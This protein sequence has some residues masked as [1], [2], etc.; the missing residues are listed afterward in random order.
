MRVKE[1]SAGQACVFSAGSVICFCKEQGRASQTYGCVS[2][3]MLPLSLIPL[4][5]TPPGQRSRK[6]FSLS[7]ITILFAC[8]R[9]KSRP[10]HPSGPVFLIFNRARRP[11][12][13]SLICFVSPS[14]G[15]AVFTQLLVNGGANKK[16]CARLFVMHKQEAG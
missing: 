13:F 15:A 5:L 12:P 10:F 9:I 8:A 4:R 6:V 7:L 2:G 1:H 14:A 3:T 11:L 16:T